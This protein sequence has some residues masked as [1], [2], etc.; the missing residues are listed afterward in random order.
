VHHSF[1]DSDSG[2][3]N[4]DM[5]QQ[6]KPNRGRIIL[7]GDGSE[8]LTDSD[9]T[10]MFDHS[11]EDK[12]LEIQAHKNGLAQDAGEKEESIP[13]QSDALPEKLSSPPSKSEETLPATAASK[14]SISKSS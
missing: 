11:A 9:D 4:M 7:L 13:L 2:Y 14:E 3:D 10:E 8:I 1:E 12:D 5:E 6:A